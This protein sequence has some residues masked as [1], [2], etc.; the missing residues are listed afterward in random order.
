MPASTGPIP[1]EIIREILS[2]LS[3]PLRL[4]EP[5]EFPWYLGQ[6]C[7]KWRA[8]FLSMQ[9]YFWNEI[10]MERPEDRETP[11]QWIYSMNDPKPELPRNRRPDSSRTMTILAFFLDVA[12]GAPFSFTLYKEDSYYS[13]Q[14]V[15]C[16]QL[17]LPKLMD[18]SMQWENVSMRLRLPEFLLLRS[19]KSRLPLLQ[20]LELVI[21]YRHEMEEDNHEV[22]LLPQMGDIFEDA[23]LLQHIELLCLEDAAWKFN[24]ASLTSLHLRYSDSPQTIITTL[25]QTINLEALDIESTNFDP[26]PTHVNA[27][28]IK[29]PY[30]EYLSIEGVFLLTI[31]ETPALKELEIAFDAG[32]SNDART[33]INF[34]LRSNCELSVLSLEN[35]ELWAHKQVLLHTPDLEELTLSHDEF[36]VEVVKWLAGSTTDAAQARE[37]P[38]QSLN[39]LSLCSY[40]NINNSHLQAVQEMIKSRHSTVD[41]SIKRLQELDIETDGAWV[42]S[43]RVLESLESLCEEEEIDFEFFS[44]WG[45]D[46]VLHKAH[47][48]LPD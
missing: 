21:P 25:Q 38:L 8:I 7:S 14:E 46:P 39:S 32:G 1:V 35:L 20:S 48:F 3:S 24:W 23:P 18:Y 41:A 11:L 13:D 6:I 22:T 30:L 9:A 29:L 27:K 43:S 45:W 12:R 37:L 17:V 36:L 40:S 47:V 5:H 15:S 31:L 42:G 26:D 28:T 19:V 2:H 4:L 34:F 44:R 16:V 10:E 33:A